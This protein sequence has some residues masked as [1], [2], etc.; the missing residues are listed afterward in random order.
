MS[1]P[2]MA[3]LGHSL[4]QILV[5]TLEEMGFV[6]ALEAEPGEEKGLHGIAVEVT[7]TGPYAGS[8]WLE[9]SPQ[10]LPTMSASMLAMD[11]VPGRVLQM[12]ALG[13]LA[14]V[15]CGNVLPALAGPRAVFALGD[16]EPASGPGPEEPEA[17]SLVILD[18]GWAEARL[19]VHAVPP[20]A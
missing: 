1:P 7:F 6:F 13:E 2:T 11:G 18:D 3:E 14:N 17:Q 16:P 12:D 20:T 19:V 9:V 10:V 15:I 5:N 4:T 8:L